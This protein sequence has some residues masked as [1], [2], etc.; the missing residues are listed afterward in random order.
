MTRIKVVSTTWAK[1]RVSLRE[2]RDI[3]FI[4]EQGVSRDLEWD[5]LDEGAEH[6]L[7]YYDDEPVGCARLLENKK[8][9]RMAV[10]AAYRKHGIG[11]EL[12]D[13]ITRHASQKR[14]TRLELSAQCHAYEF[15]RRSGYQ[16]SSSPY[17]DAN[18]PHIDMERR[19]FSHEEVEG[20]KYQIGYDSKIYHGTSLLEAKG[21]LDICLSQ[22]KRAFVMCVKD[23]SHPLFNYDNL[24]DRMKLLARENK[25][26]KAYVLLG[27]YHPTYN[28]TTLFKLADKLPSF[29]EIKTTQEAIP[30]QWI[31]DASAWF[32][33]EGA[34][35]RVCYSDRGKIKNFMERFNKWWY[36]AKHIQD[37]RRLSI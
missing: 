29:I 17:E 12:L 18:I 35:S 15:Y 36:H 14:Y 27:N 11:R 13:H 32:D 19:V 37:A 1:D 33:F 4:Q 31:I 23:I 5:D 16:A 21:Y 34:D 30:C 26:F 2:I 20:S 28:D 24:F 25:H 6:F 8:V 10:L 3:V 7:A 9:G 22:S